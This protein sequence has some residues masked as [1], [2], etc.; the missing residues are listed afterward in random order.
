[1]G[2]TGLGKGLAVRHDYSKD[3]QN[4]YQ[5]ENMR[6]Q[7]QQ[8]KQRKAEYYGNI[9]KGGHV[10]GEYNTQRLEEH[11]NDLNGRLSNFVSENPGW[12]TD[13]GLYAQF[14]SITDEYINNDII[15][16]DMQV[17]KQF[18]ALQSESQRGTMTGGEIANE[19]AKYD[20]YIR[21]G[22]D[23]YVFIN[24]KKFEYSD[25]LKE[26]SAAIGYSQEVEL[27]TRF[28]LERSR[29]V[30]Q[31]RD[32]SIQS[33]VEID[34]NNPDKKRSI[35]A[36]WRSAGG[37]EAAPTARQWHAENLDSASTYAESKWTYDQHQLALARKRLET[38]GYSPRSIAAETFDYYRQSME[39]GK[40][41]ESPPSSSNIYLT[42]FA[43][44]G[45]YWNVNET[46]D[47]HI[48][49]ESGNLIPFKYTANMKATGSGSFFANGK[50]PYSQVDVEL[51]IPLDKSGKVTD[52]AM[53]NFLDDNKF[54]SKKVTNYA[55]FS[56][57]KDVTVNAQVYN[58]TI[59]APAE[60]SR[61]N[62]NKIDAETFSAR[63]MQEK[64]RSNEYGMLA[65]EA[66]LLHLRR[67]SS[68]LNQN[69]KLSGYNFSPKNGEIV[70]ENGKYG[71]DPSAGKIYT[72]E[73]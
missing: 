47:V 23:P 18:E 33:R 28:G 31:P 39:T 67:V 3:I 17:Q 56:Y 4:L 60:F 20:T 68:E 12:E 24:P 50:K 34:F 8:E 13:P 10:K 66:D 22:G 61:E 62:M 30:R 32:G 71:Y 48:R 26:S 2:Q 16:E 72:I 57:G 38:G 41:I 64:R 63:E 73:Q 58:G 43:R 45:G 7:I 25:I 55:T 15:R 44:V 19:T 5:R 35:E 11:Y 1:M 9:L 21:E 6:A 36:Q 52:T 49:D 14:A 29:T 42:P 59:F 27:G 54:T 70:S 69:P 37:S 40:P 46:S 65:Y 51:Y 53:A